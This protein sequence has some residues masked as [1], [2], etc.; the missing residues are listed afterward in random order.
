MILSGERIV[1]NDGANL[2]IPRL[3]LA[4]SFAYSTRNI[5]DINLRNRGIRFV[6]LI[7]VSMSF[8]E[9]DVLDAK[10]W[11]TADPKCRLILSLDQ[12]GMWKVVSSCRSGEGRLGSREENKTVE[13]KYMS[14]TGIVIR[15]SAS[16][17]QK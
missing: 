3:F 6:N 12:G 13:K 11:S 5:I 15:R 4:S 2:V 9:I 8:I 17:V 10:T 7:T 14:C 1:S 16:T